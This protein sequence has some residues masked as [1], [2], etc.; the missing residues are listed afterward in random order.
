MIILIKCCKRMGSG[1]LASS[2]SPLEFSNPR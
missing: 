1:N 2:S